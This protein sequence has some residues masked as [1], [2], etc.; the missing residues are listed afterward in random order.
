VDAAYVLVL[1]FLLAQELQHHRALAVRLG[2][3]KVRSILKVHVTVLCW[4]NETAG[5]H[6]ILVQSTPSHY[7][8]LLHSERTV[9]QG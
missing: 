9:S 2:S 1:F 4:E 6:D 7:A 5:M 8:R 3:E